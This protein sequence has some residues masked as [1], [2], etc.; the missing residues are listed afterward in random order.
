MEVNLLQPL[1]PFLQS[2]VWLVYFSLSAG[3]QS[4]ANLAIL[5]LAA[6]ALA[7][8]ATAVQTA[9]VAL[10]I[11]ISTSSNYCAFFCRV[12]PDLS[13]RRFSLIFAHWDLRLS[14]SSEGIPLVTLLIPYSGT[15]S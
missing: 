14:A 9:L 8:V 1:V 3:F 5:V 11:E 10:A 6:K 15:L 4:A 7:A 2:W 13:V 12:P